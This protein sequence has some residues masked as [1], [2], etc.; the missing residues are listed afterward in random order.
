MA[1]PSCSPSATWRPPDG[2][3][4]NPHEVV[5]LAEI[6]G[7]DRRTSKSR[8]ASKAFGSR[9][10][11]GAVLLPGLHLPA[12]EIQYGRFERILFLPSP[13]TRKR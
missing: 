12:A 13:I 6:G 5:I 10:A 4:R 2:H 9:A 8:S 3:V 11:A 1:P 7:V